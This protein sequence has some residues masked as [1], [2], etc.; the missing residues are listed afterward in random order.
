M[1][2]AIHPKT[3]FPNGSLNQKLFRFVF[4]GPVFIFFVA[5]AT[6]TKLMVKSEPQ[7]TRNVEKKTTVTTVA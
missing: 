1:T 2:N 6:Q 3:V 4:I 5:V 7:L